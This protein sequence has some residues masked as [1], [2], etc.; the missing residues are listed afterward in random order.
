MDQLKTVVRKTEDAPPV[1]GTAGVGSDTEVTVTTMP[2]WQMVAVRA[3]RVYLQALVGFLVVGGTGLGEAA[4]IPLEQ[5]GG[6]LK[7]AATLAVAPSV[8]SLLQNLLEFLTK[9]DITNPGIR[10]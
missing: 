2:W 8:V 3:A 7:V 1:V 6:N 10:A 4:G 9:L 5:F